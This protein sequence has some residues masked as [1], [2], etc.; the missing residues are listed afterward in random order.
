MDKTV[1]GLIGAV[2]FAASGPAH[3]SS[4]TSTS[5]TVLAAQSYADLLKPI[6]NAPALARPAGDASA[7]AVPD[8]SLQLVQYHHHHHHRYY[9]HR[10]HY[11]YHHHHHD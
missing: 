5:E 7:D 1:A 6:P 11:Q 3:A 2:A 8:G 4:L 9:R 10:R